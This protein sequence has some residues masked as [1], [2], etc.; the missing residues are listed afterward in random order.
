LVTVPVMEAACANVAASSKAKTEKL[1][2][3]RG[4]F[5][6]SEYPFGK[7]WLL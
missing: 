1:D 2:G 4:N 5:I 3:I 6:F 7:S